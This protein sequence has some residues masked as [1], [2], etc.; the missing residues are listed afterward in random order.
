MKKLVAAAAVLV[1]LLVFAPWGVGKLAERHVNGGLDQALEQ[2]PYFKIAE[3]KYTPGWFSSEQVLTFELSSPWQKLLEEAMAGKQT[4]TTASVEEEDD[5]GTDLFDD[6]NG[7]LSSENKSAPDSRFTVRNKIQHGPVLW[8]FGFGAARVRTEIVWSDEVRERLVRVFGDDEPFRIVSRVGFFGGGTTT[9]LSAKRSIKP[10]EGGEISWDDFEFNVHYTRDAS[11]MS[12]DGE[13]PR[14]EARSK[15][16]GYFLLRDF[17]AEGSGDRIVGD[18]YDTEAVFEID[19]I[20]VVDTQGETVEAKDI[21]YRIDTDRKGDFVDV[22]FTFGTGPVTAKQ[23][24]LTELHYDFS[25]RHLHAASFDALMKAVKQSYARAVDE[26]TEVSLG[27]TDDEK[28]TFFDLLNH[29][30]EFA[31]DR[32]G[33]ATK[34]GDGAIKGVLRFNGVTEADFAMGGL[35]LIGKLE[36]EFDIDFSEAL[37]KELGGGDSSAVDMVVGEGYAVRKGDRVTSRIEF[38]AGELTIN[39]K[40]QAIPGFGAPASQDT[41]AMA[42]PE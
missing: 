6:D 34:A 19:S 28:Q 20:R 21:E 9:F 10:G 38:K 16:G 37:I 30:P 5:S 41:D 22:S 18:V 13:W 23:F 2:M 14:L 1:A 25:L 31:I 35:G 15:G 4:R 17:E 7:E 36:A 39:G 26:T 40:T 24:T 27:M 32:I 12:F 29:K 8:P 3:R 42:G 33:F 11:E